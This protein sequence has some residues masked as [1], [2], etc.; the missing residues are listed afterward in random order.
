[1]K[2]LS[3]PISLRMKGPKVADLHAALTALGY[4][5]ESGEVAK[6][7]YGASTRSAVTAFQK[8]HKLTVNGS[9]D[10]VTSE[11]I[12]KLLNLKDTKSPS[13]PK[14]EKTNEQIGKGGGAPGFFTVTGRVTSATNP[15]VGGL[16]VVIV[17]KTVGKDIGLGEAV[18]DNSGAYRLNISIA[19]LAKQKKAKPDLQAQAYLGKKFLA[20]SK[21][22]YDAVSPTALNVALDA[23][24][25]TLLP[26]E[27]ETL[28]GVISEHYKGKL[29]NLKENRTRQD[30]TYL[31][32]KS[33]W[34]ARA[35]ALAAL[36][37]QFSARG[38]KGG[39]TISPA[40]FYALFRAG[41]PANEEAL[42]RLTPGAIERVWNQAIEYHVVPRG[43]KK[44]LPHALEY[45]RQVAAEKTL[46][47][48]AVVGVS[49]LKDI[50]ALS[51]LDDSKKRQF[52]DLYSVHKAD[53]PKF[54]GAVTKAFGSPIADRLKLDGKLSFLTIN[55]AKLMQKLHTAAGEKG[56]SDPL[57][58]AQQGYH[59]AEKWK[60]LLTSDLPIPEEIP[61]KSKAAKRANYANYLAAQ[62]RVSYPTASIA[63]MVKSGELPL[64]DATQ[65]ERND[66][67]L[68]L[69]KRQ[70]KF[71]F[72]VQ[73]ILQYLAHNK[74]KDETKKTVEL[75]KRLERV[76]QITP[77]DKAMI[78]LMK[79]G[80]DSAYQVTA[81]EKE[82]FTRAFA[83]DLG[84]AKAAEKTYDRAMQV[85]NVVLNIALSYQTAKNGV[86]IGGRA[87]AAP[88]EPRPR[89]MARTAP[90]APSPR[91][92]AMAAPT[93]SDQIINPTPT[94]PAAHAEDIVAYSALDTMFPTMDF[95]ECEHCRSILSPAAYLV[96]LLMFI[97]K[98]G[99]GEN[100]P[101]Q[102]LL[103]R[104]PDI[105]HLPLTCEN[106]NTAL[107]YIDLVNETLEYFIAN[108][109][110]ENS[111]NGYMGHD[112][113]G[114]S[115]AD[116]LASPQHVIDSAYTVLRRDKFPLALPFH[117]PLE[118]LRRYFS[119]FEIELPYAM[120]KLNNSAELD[121]DRSANPATDY[122]WRDIWMEELALS[123]AEHELLTNQPDSVTLAQLYGFP[124]G[125]S[126]Q[127]V[128]A[129]L[130]N[131]KG[132]TQRLD[133]TYVD[134]VSI[135]KTR[136]VNPNSYLL[137]RLEQL[138]LNFAAL[139]VLHTAPESIRDAVNERLR[140][141]ATQIDVTNFGVA[142]T[143]AGDPPDFAQI[144]ADWMNQEVNDDH[145]TIYDRIMGV[146][147]L[148]NPGA[149]VAPDLGV[150]DFKFEDL[151]LRYAE[152]IAADGPPDVSTRLDSV[153][154][155]R[156]IRFVRLW[157]KL[158]WTIEETD[159]AICAVFPQPAAG[160]TFSNVVD[161]I[162]DLDADFLIALPRL[163][164]LKRAMRMLTLSAKRDL[165]PLLSCWSDIN[166]HGEN[167]LY[168]QMFLNPVFL[169]ANLAGA[170]EVQSTFAANGA[171]EFLVQNARLVDHV[172]IVRS[173]FNLTAEEYA[174]IAEALLYDENTL[175]TLGTISNIF[176]RGWLAR[177]LKI[178]VRELLLLIKH[179]GLHPFVPPISVPA[180][181]L[182]DPEI[183][184]VIA[185]V[186][187][188]K[189]R[190][191]KP[192]NALY[193]IWNQDL[194][195]E[196]S[197][198][199]AK[200]TEFARTLREDFAG[201]DS[202]LT[203][204][205]LTSDD[206]AE[207]Q[208][209]MVYGQETADQFFAILDRTV[210]V[211]T[212]YV[213]PAPE[214]SEAITEL[215]PQL[216]YDHFRGRL[217]HM[218][219][220][221]SIPGEQLKALG[222]PAFKHAIDA[223]ILSSEDVALSFF[224]LHKELEPL[225][226]Q[227]GTS[228]TPTSI[229]AAYVFFNS[230]QRSVD[231][232]PV[233]DE[234]S[235]GPE[236]LAAAE[237]RLSYDG[238]DHK[239]T[240]IGY[241]NP[242]MRDK[243]KAV[244]NM[245]NAFAPAIDSLFS[246][247]WTAIT[248]FF[249]LHVDL[250]PGPYLAADNNK[251][252]QRV[253]MLANLL[254]ELRRKRKRLQV[255]QR[256][257]SA[258]GLDLS[259]AESLLDGGGPPFPLHSNADRGQPVLNDFLAV[260]RPGLA[261]D[262]FFG[263]ST[264]GLPDQKIETSAKLEYSISGNNPLP[265][266]SPGE[267]ISAIWK[268]HLEAAES[269][270]HNIVVA[271][272]PEDSNAEVQI[273]FDGA[274]LNLT[275]GAFWRNTTP[276]ELKA[277]QLY[278][279]T[280]TIKKVRGPL[281][282]NWETPNTRRQTIP[283]RY[284]YPPSIFAPFSAGYIR[285]LK[286]ASLMTGLKLTAGELAHF[287]T[288]SDH[289]IDGDGWLNQLPI[290]GDA[291][292]EGPKEFTEV[293]T[294]LLDYA[295]IKN[296]L[297]AADTALLTVLQDPLAKTPKGDELL[298]IL[299]GWDSDS[300]N[301]LLSHFTGDNDRVAL[302]QFALF[303]RV[304]GAFELIQQMGLSGS[305]LIAATTNEPE[306][307]TVGNFQSALRSRYGVSEWR[308][309]VQPLNDAMRAAQR[310][311]LV[312]HIL[313]N[314]RSHPESVHI[315]TVDKLFEY[316]LMDVQMDPCMQTSRVR[317]A[318]S[319]IQ[320]FIERCLMNLERRVEASNINAKQWEWMKR[321]RVWEANRKVFI[322]PENW[323][324]PELRDDK[325]PFF[326]EIE[327]EL[328]QSD[329]TEESAASALITY[330]SKLGEVANLEP[331][332]IYHVPETDNTREVNHIISR[333]SGANRKY[334]YRRQEGS[335]W[336]PWEQI[337]LE[338]EDNPVV[339]V[340]WKDRLL[341]FWLK[342][343]KQ[344]PLDPDQMHDEG[345]DT[346]PITEANLGDIKSNA[347]ASGQNN[348]KTQV[349][350]VLCWSEYYNNKWQAVKTSDLARP[351]F[352]GSYGSNPE[353]IDS[354]HRETLHLSTSAHMIDE[355]NEQALVIHI[356]YRDE[357][358]FVFYNPQSLPQLN[359][360]LPFHPEPV[361]SRYID[362]SD[363]LRIFYFNTTTG[364][365]FRDVLALGTNAL[366]IT[367]TQPR[368]RRGFEWEYPFLLHDNR[369]TFFVKT[370]AASAP[371]QENQYPFFDNFLTNVLQFSP[372]LVINP[373]VQNIVTGPKIVLGSSATRK[374]ASTPVPREFV[375]EDAYIAPAYITGPSVK[376]GNLPIGSSG[377]IQRNFKER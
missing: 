268:G 10:K 338:I 232:L 27:Y 271:T 90:S 367:P 178:S 328:L 2:I 174:L 269:G 352:I 307:E 109:E 282:I 86:G 185:L 101:Q 111:L 39:T 270:Y 219:F 198:D 279:I 40:L 366:P 42:Y 122:A 345:T 230:L 45:F 258:F 112:T 276:L 175:L 331:C 157:K 46:N 70:G 139:E 245:P 31:A 361:T 190:S 47:G 274:M 106:T 182:T 303:K 41:L 229:Y 196:F 214:L 221:G 172:E 306:P 249:S 153:D 54:W 314:F 26:S 159:A 362:T 167:S 204:S 266:P 138:G 209:A 256:F 225:Y 243:L 227:P 326:K 142:P 163:A 298:P 48:P 304:Y 38:A 325:S 358:Y 94:G 59:R 262:V 275:N 324:E 171:G 89:A 244:P 91:A 169:N 368:L 252:L 309:L 335:S 7:V 286:A 372:L 341:L 377:S 292:P 301:A 131:A 104:R 24:S 117:R 339:P 371:F 162:G 226:R 251:N 96:D 65:H 370:K 3:F 137:P 58:L 351:A 264:A 205:N 85:H 19:E 12:N 208:V 107:P 285:F 151:E 28:I 334:Y 72:G 376:Y 62:V 64:K 281:S 240:F 210:L 35:V 354:F 344:T 184:K 80:V 247:I 132:F 177:K 242:E 340:V 60:D 76:F 88:T 92:M 120:E 217:S 223:L 126:D 212:E 213:Q 123:R 216:R 74:L 241:L 79:R 215:D 105:Q 291:P 305:A 68:F 125:E 319:S 55:N 369:Y 224:N 317:N 97:D 170:P 297:G 61:G 337:K 284:L 179:S 134:L 133:I 283:G 364:E 238:A 195:G 311:A 278:P 302:K 201:I 144:V 186:R 154:F 102:V 347:K 181:G 272:D 78:G 233:P 18:T 267:N 148:T 353:S 357:P 176:R 336:T 160:E 6:Q 235:L 273:E 231:Y 294:D 146:I 136:F 200:I 250:S 22:G 296:N 194:G 236:V 13:E 183:L 290:L 75:I 165:L 164:I 16:R 100:N 99:E 313:H 30:I 320:L 348:L 113:R 327:S 288:Q 356:G 81:Y 316:F 103:E 69:N 124:D 322:T 116:L 14:G 329:I 332:G 346:K 82:S 53:M 265:N 257:A 4:K 343:L 77:S 295:R 23:Q 152:P 239:L 20:A 199:P 166:T 375:T 318:L 321:Y 263:N 34:D 33:G 289:L 128:V 188:L 66:V 173:A 189:D 135:L 315:D 57:Q 237:G 87:M 206:G 11:I 220:L 342:I 197:S 145:E 191:L 261:V 37:E 310:D 293:L 110:R 44:E 161:S 248:T 150:S 52:S 95:C 218:G 1:M 29:S 98:P 228:S 50:L 118:T 9:V 32:N 84:G 158:G 350:A 83:K 287:A 67:H 43:L 140:P 63:E 15:A 333:T 330:L 51:R 312:A 193:L 192:A 246:E 49:S 259:S 8:K 156:F 299:T 21:V 253:I 121:M 180:S 260:E 143:D 211:D 280:I 360:T 108:T 141:R 56:L 36:A 73:P 359:G 374:T 119:K 17:D 308:D 255:L 25:S 187:A 71:E 129:Q 349:S 147:T 254:P 93:A 203:V 207:K 373:A 5:L 323:L 168:R 202:Q 363:N 300:L 355:T 234:G 149:D 127:N 130:S 277:G 155:V 114:I 115:S 365:F 222:T